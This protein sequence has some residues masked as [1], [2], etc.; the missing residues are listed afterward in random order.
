M[1]HQSL[2]GSPGLV[3]QNSWSWPT[4]AKEWL[5]VHVCVCV[6][7]AKATQCFF[8]CR[9]AITYTCSY[10]HSHNSINEMLPHLGQIIKK[11]WS[12]KIRGRCWECWHMY[13]C[14]FVY[15]HKNVS[16]SLHQFSY[17]SQTLNTIMFGSLTQI[18]PKSDNKCGKQT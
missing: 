3:V 11:R 2:K 9:E 10:H 15:A 14:T 13:R 5:S 4:T 12:G 6:C 17:N 1:I 8:K 18:S 16:P 7:V